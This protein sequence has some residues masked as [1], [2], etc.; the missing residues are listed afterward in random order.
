MLQGDARGDDVRPLVRAAARDRDQ[1]VARE[2]LA[3]LEL[4]RR[5]A[6]VLAAVVI[7]REQEGVRHLPAEAPRHVDELR[8][9][10]DRG[11]RH[12]E[13]LGAHDAV[14]IR[15]DDLG[16]AVDHEAKRPTHRDHGQRLERRIQCQTANDHAEPPESFVRV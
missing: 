6:A 4:D 13:P 2:R 7:A 10:D 15:F 8:Q 11:A 1:V 9:P 16:L 14:V 3:R 12:R 5:A